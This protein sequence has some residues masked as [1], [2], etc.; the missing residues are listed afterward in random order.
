MS[1]SSKRS[2]KERRSAAKKQS[3]A[4]KKARYAAYAEAGEN[5]KRGRIRSKKEG[6]DLRT[7]PKA[8]RVV[9]YS[10]VRTVRDGRLGFLTVRQTKNQVSLAQFLKVSK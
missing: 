10:A 5:S 8:P 7:T 9:Q 2:G 4:A 1:S 6:R 3:K